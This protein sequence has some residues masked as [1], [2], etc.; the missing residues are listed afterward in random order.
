MERSTEDGGASERRS[1]REAP[2]AQFAESMGGDA[3]PSPGLWLLRTIETEIIPRLMLAHGHR[4]TQATDIAEVDGDVIAR[5]DVDSFTALVLRDDVEACFEFVGALR[6]RGVALELVYLELV[7]PTARRLGRMWEDDECD[8]AQVT[9]GLWRLQNLVYELSPQLPAAWHDRPM[10]PRRALL[11]AAPGSQHTLGLLLVSEFFRRAGW[12]VWSD[13]CATGDDLVAQVRGEWFDVIGL[14]V[15]VDVH[16]ETLG[17][18]I[19][20]LRRASRN[21]AVAV[22]V[23]GP[24][25]ASGRQQVVAEIGADFTATDARQAVERADAFVATRHAQP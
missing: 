19:V 14:S 3:D 2:R 5:G 25:V 23:G 10:P 11:A 22:M 4:G 17:S 21:P 7:T 1:T 24:I 12:D 9:L 20:G 13:P 16:V 15:A 18:V 6:E 8:F